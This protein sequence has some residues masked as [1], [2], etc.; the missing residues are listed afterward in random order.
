MEKIG[1]RL[2]VAAGVAAV[3]TLLLCLGLLGFLDEP[4]GFR[5]YAAACAFLPGVQLAGGF[6]FFGYQ[7]RD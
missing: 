1:R 5:L 3:I 2:I 6:A 7:L 4:I